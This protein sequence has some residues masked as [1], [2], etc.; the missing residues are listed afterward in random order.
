VALTRYVP[1]CIAHNILQVLHTGSSGIEICEGTVSWLRQL[2]AGFLP[3]WPR[4]NP[5]SGHVGFMSYEVA[6]GWVFL[7]ILLGFSCQFSLHQLLLIHYS[8]YHWF[9]IVSILT[10]SLNDQLFGATFWR[11]SLLLP[12]KSVFYVQMWVSRWN[13]LQS[14]L[15][16]CSI[17]FFI[18]CQLFPLIFLFSITIILG[19]SS[20]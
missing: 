15:L 3:L 1:S 16:C 13:I 14:F 18:Y 2:V 11:T 6:L 10:V 4:F 17:F 5:R 8:S 19:C 7:Q 9:H 20:I 12:P